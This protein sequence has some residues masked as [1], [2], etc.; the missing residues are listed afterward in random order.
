M[1][2]IDL[3]WIIPDDLCR[4]LGYH[5]R[6]P[7]VAPEPRARRCGGRHT[8]LRSSMPRQDAQRLAPAGEL[9]PGYLAPTVPTVEALAGHK[10]AINQNECP[11]QA[12]RRSDDLDSLI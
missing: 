1:Y 4:S 6:P 8:A 5:R 9:P 11:I 12:D 2:T 10:R 7:A 3:R